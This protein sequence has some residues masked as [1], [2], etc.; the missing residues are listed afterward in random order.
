MLNRGNKSKAWN[1][2]QNRL[3]GLVVVSLIV[4]IL[5]F[6]LSVGNNDQKPSS[7]LQLPK[8]K[9]NSFESLVQL[10]P[11]LE[12]RNGTDV[13]W[14]IPD[15]PKAVLFLAH[16]CNGRAAHFW[17]ESSHCPNCIGLPK[18]RLTALHDLARK[19]AVLTISRADMCWTLGK[20]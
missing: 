6:I 4:F 5:I 20:R 7:L 3:A 14:K 15:F 16:G 19:F 11:T 1:G 12:F 2:T 10:S 18:E 13:I 9:W 17:D 8:E